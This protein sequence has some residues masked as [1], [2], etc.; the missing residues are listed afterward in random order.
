VVILSA[1]PDYIGMG[2]S[3]GLHPYVHAASEATASIDMIR[4]ARE[5]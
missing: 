5:F 1:M 3:P 2:G 4:A